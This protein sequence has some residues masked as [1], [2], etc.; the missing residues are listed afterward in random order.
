[1]VA[2][3]TAPTL[4]TGDAAGDTYTTIEGL[5]GS[6]FADILGGTED[7]NTMTALGGHDSLAGFGGADTLSGNEGDDSL[8]GGAGGDGLFGGNGNDFARYD[9]ALGGVIASLS[10][11]AANSGDAAGD[12]YDSIEG[13]VG[14]AVADL[15]GG[16]SSANT[17]YGLS[18]DDSIFGL[19]GADSL[20]GG[21]GADR[22]SYVA[23][24]EGG[25]L[26]ADFAQGLDKINVV[27][28]NFGGLPG[29]TLAVDRFANWTATQAF[30]QFI[31]NPATDTLP[32]DA[33][34]T[35]G[36]A[37]V[38]IATFMGVGD[39]NHTDIVVI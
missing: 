18:G 38:L 8:Y 16:N 32:W 7:A 26:I 4:N 33:D 2:Y 37:A 31:W 23:S 24:G 20:I 27:G 35:G 17:L 1:V 14:S 29:G 3:L 9:D 36:A 39:L 13:V 19:G 34:G 21:L 12:V 6:N 28:T 30:G 10:N 15:I 22:F 5:I 11:A 25:D